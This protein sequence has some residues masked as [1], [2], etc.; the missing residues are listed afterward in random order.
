MQNF[1]HFILDLFDDFHQNVKKRINYWENSVLVT[2]CSAILGKQ[3]QMSK[4]FQNVEFWRKTL[5]KNI[6][7]FKLNAVRIA[8]IIFLIFL[9]IGTNAQKIEFEI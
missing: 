2:L 6:K 3:R 7:V 1:K 9:N 8:L 5:T 4:S